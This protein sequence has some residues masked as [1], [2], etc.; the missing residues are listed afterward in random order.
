MSF[1][2]PSIR[3]RR[4]QAFTVSDDKCYYP[5]EKLA[6]PLKIHRRVPAARFPTDKTAE[7]RPCPRVSYTKQIVPL[8]RCR[9]VRLIVRSGHKSDRRARTVWCA[10]LQSFAER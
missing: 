1:P 3:E 9:D 10:P 2:N 5:F 7:N 8:R 4:N 6:R